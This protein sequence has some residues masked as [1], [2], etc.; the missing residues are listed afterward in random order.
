MMF[1][2]GFLLYA[3]EIAGERRVALTPFERYLCMNSGILLG[4]LGFAL[5]FNVRYILCSQIV[6]V[7]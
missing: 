4:T 6:V 7:F 5:L 3:A 2:P 1:F